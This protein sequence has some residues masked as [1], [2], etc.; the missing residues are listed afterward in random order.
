MIEFTPDE[1]E[2]LV[3]AAHQQWM[4]AK[5]SDGWKL[6][7][8]T[9]SDYKNHTELKPYAELDESQKQGWRSLVSGLPQVLE[10]AGYIIISREEWEAYRID[11][12]R[13][14]QFGDNPQ[15]G[16]QTELDGAKLRRVKV[17]SGRGNYAYWYKNLPKGED[18][19]WFVVVDMMDNPMA[20]HRAGRLLEA[21]EGKPGGEAWLVMGS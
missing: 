10:P 21:H 7:E 6:G 11:L 3:R 9:R 19:G 13:R 5:L 18:A 8:R 4:L 12:Q 14:P 1:L 15:L 16:D 2:P 20:S 17:I